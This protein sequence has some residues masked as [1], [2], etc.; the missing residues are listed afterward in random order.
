MILVHYFIPPIP[1]HA[2]SSK[3]MFCPYYL[4]IVKKTFFLLAETTLR[5]FKNCTVKKCLIRIQWILKFSHNTAFSVKI[6]YIVGLFLKKQQ[7]KHG[8]RGSKKG[9]AK[10]KNEKERGKK[11]MGRGIG[12]LDGAV[13]LNMIKEHTKY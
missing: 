12:I 4:R 5:L 7:K 10:D 2:T 9:G 11:W 3:N 6:C 1:I 13:E 8:K